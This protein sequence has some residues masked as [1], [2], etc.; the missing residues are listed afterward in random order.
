MRVQGYVLLAVVGMCRDWAEKGSLSVGRG[1]GGE[2]LAD[3][4]LEAWE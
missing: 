1:E 4:G 2:V 3:T